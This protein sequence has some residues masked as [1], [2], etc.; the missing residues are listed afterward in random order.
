MKTL[1]ILLA[2]FLSASH[3][4]AQNPVWSKRYHK[5][6]RTSLAISN[7]GSKIATG[8]YEDGIL[9]WSAI[10][11]DTIRKYSQTLPWI[12]YLEFAPND[13]W[14]LSYERGYGAWGSFHRY[15]LGDSTD[16]IVWP[17]LKMELPPHPPQNNYSVGPPGDVSPFLINDSLI[18]CFMNATGYIVP[19]Y[20]PIEKMISVFNIA[21]YNLRTGERDTVLRTNFE[22]LSLAIPS[23]SREIF[24]IYSKNLGELFGKQSQ[25]I[26][27]TGSIAA[28][29]K[30][31]SIIVIAQ[32]S[33][34]DAYS[35]KGNFIQ[36]I[37]STGLP[38]T[39]L[40]VDFK[41][42]YYVSTH[43]DSTIRLWSPGIPNIYKSFRLMTR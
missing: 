30:D 34:I 24:Y 12:H 31:D 38:A 41:N 2:L 7:D 11:G 18:I 32:D 14:F 22:G 29:S 36:N 25:I 21:L 39:A 8:A 33:S 9:L 28:F 13:T 6:T 23:Y 15:L 40:G 3:A 43:T 5:N 19:P 35:T 1:V 27:N 10:G 42:R 26:N 37:K 20:G 17:I 16:K 4:F